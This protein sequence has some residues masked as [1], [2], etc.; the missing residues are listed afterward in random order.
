M[1]NC[2]HRISPSHR[3]TSTSWGTTSSSRSSGGLLGVELGVGLDVR[4]LPQW[5][6]LAFMAEG[7]SCW[8]LAL[9]NGA[10]EAEV[11]SLR[12]ERNALNRVIESEEACMK[13]LLQGI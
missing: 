4:E 11:R 10:S 5:K 3:E 7:R 6:Y 1:A 8:D 12:N 9:R 2:W 13:R